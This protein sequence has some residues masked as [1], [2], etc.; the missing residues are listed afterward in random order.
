MKREGDLPLNRSLYN[1][2]HVHKHTHTLSVLYIW[3][4]IHAGIYALIGATA[5]LAGVFRSS[6]SLVVIVVEGTRAV[7]FLLPLVIAALVANWVAALL[8]KDGVYESELER[9]GTVFFLRH[10]VPRSLKRLLV[11]DV[12]AP[13]P[14]TMHPIESVAT[15][16]HALRSTPH[17]GT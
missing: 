7:D 6:I 10:E 2:I 15:V 1:H 3:S 12:M 5:S 8:H 13:E 17:N 9:D 16:L 4:Y 14:V 11:R